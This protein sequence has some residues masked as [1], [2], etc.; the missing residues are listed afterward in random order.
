MNE[1]S[2]P[3]E[4]HSLSS[5]WLDGWSTAAP[6][7]YQGGERLA[8]Q[9]W[10]KFKEAFSPTLVHSIIE[11]LPRRPRRI[12]DC[13]GGSG[14][15]GVV[16][17]FCG[18]DATL[19]E[20]NPFLADL[21]E[22]KLD[23]YEG[24]ELHLELARILDRAAAATVTVDGLRA[25]LPP[26]FVEPGVKNRWLFGKSVA[27][28]IERLRLA[29]ESSRKPS[30]RRFFLIALGS[31][32]IELSNVRVDGKGRRYRQNWQARVVSASDVRIRFLEAVGHMA[33]DVY[34][35][36][37]RRQGSTTVLRGDARQLLC[38]IKDPVD[39]VLFSPP[40]PNSF[41]YTDIYNVELWMLGYFTCAKDNIELRR[42]TLRSHV[43]VSWD[44]PENSINNTTLRRT[45]RQLS[46]KR[47]SLWDRRLPEMVQAYFE[48]MRSLLF[49][50]QSCLS[51]DARIAIVVGD[52]SYAQIHIDSARILISIAKKLGWHLESR[53]SARVMRA[54]MQHN[55]GEKALDE[56]LLLFRRGGVK[57]NPNSCGVVMNRE[58]A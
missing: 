7:T 9:R 58:V 55:R 12:L 56:W 2:V 3:S 51:E 32:L 43:Q 19:I 20:V 18:I 25:S 41:D 15:T 16:A 24:I 31:C 28:E 45:V 36:T 33:R 38:D 27:K 21:I 34:R 29:I 17:R 42:R 50:M 13:C 39:L 37:H 14:T 54:S 5:A 44:A 30:V 11:K 49:G 48:D 40:Y 26:T 10:F 52:S 22:A 53:E 4:Y 47:E 57:R 1:K 35:H 23:D 6:T 46:D 8:F